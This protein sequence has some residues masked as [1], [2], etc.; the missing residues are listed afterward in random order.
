MTKYSKVM[1][2]V[3]EFKQVTQ[4]EPTPQMSA[5]LINEEYS[6]WL[7]ENE[8]KVNKGWI[9]P[10]KY[11]PQEELKELADLVYVIYGYADTMG[12][13]LDIALNRVHKNN[14]ERVIQEDGSV[15][16]REDGKVKKREGAPKVYLGDLV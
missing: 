3:R 1:D 4:Q 13:D 9:N 16:F 6:E 12:W 8:K 5:E 15:L 7:K 2:M 10:P 14:L 11:R